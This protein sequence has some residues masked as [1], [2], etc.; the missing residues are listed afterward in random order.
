MGIFRSIGKLFRPKEEYT[1]FTSGSEDK[2]DTVENSHGRFGYSKSNPIPVA[3]SNGET[4]YLSAL[5]CSCNQ[6]FTFHRVG[7]VGSGPDGHIIDEYDLI[8]KTGKH[9]VVLYMDMYHSG[10]SDLIPE[11]LTKAEPEDIEPR[12]ELPMNSGINSKNAEEEDHI[13]LRQLLKREFDIDYPIS[14]GIGNSLDNPIVI[15]KQ[16]HN[17]YSEVQSEIISLLDLRKGVELDV[18]RQKFFNYNDRTLNHLIIET[19]E[20][21]ENDGY[22]QTASYYFDITEFEP[23]SDDDSAWIWEPPV[24]NS[25]RLKPN[26][27]SVLD[28]L[29]KLYLQMPLRGWWWRNEDYIEGNIKGSIF[30][31]YIEHE[32]QGAYII[33][34]DATNDPT[35]PD[36]STLEHYDVAKIDKYLEEELRKGLPADGREIIQWMSSH[37]EQSEKGKE[38]T[39]AYIERQDGGDF[40]YMV[41]R[42]KVKGRKLVMMGCFDIAKKEI[43]A[44]PIIYAIRHMGIDSDDVVHKENNVE[45]TTKMIS[46]EK[47]VSKE[48]PRQILAEHFKSL[49]G[50]L[51]IR[52]GWGYT[53]KDACIIDKNDPVVD[54]ELPFD[55]GSIEY[56]FVE[57][58]IYEEMIIF[59]P[60]NDRFSG[61]RWNRLKQELIHDGD[62]VF[63]KLVFEITAFSDKDWEELKTEYE[64][65]DGYGNPNF[66]LAAHEKKRQEK[67]IHFIGEFWFD[68]TSFY[69]QGVVTTYNKTGER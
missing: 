22:S 16:D 45:Q 18:I 41:V 34:V 57:K 12:Q 62:R 24:R 20:T 17:D 42:H 21:A 63:D 1:D 55:G 9:K 13:N 47:I 29:V 10:Q 67:M 66:D 59:R 27:F 50:E 54:P 26:V 33:V 52:G 53:K 14:G 30:R 28:G 64:G 68:I 32:E 39:T 19:N 11:G 46:I 49:G 58:R 48:S 2:I 35:E 15:H 4:V 6:P 61:I 31:A 36:V 5:R 44:A 23:P 65:P 7:S 56:I 43:L 60:E 51:P 37:L 40:Q 3:R 38:L 69:G 8:C 25:E